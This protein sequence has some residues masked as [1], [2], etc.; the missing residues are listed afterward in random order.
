V[1]RK[2]E[3]PVKAKAHAPQMK[4]LALVFFDY[5]GIIYTNHAPKETM[6]KARY[7]RMSLYRLV[8]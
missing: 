1:P 8:D 3:G 4:S 7:I 2:K 5:Q 6:V